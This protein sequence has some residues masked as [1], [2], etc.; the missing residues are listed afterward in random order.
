MS[1]TAMVEIIET[2]GR[3]WAISIEEEVIKVTHGRR[4]AVD[5][6]QSRAVAQNG[7]RSLQ[8]RHQHQHRRVHDCDHGA[9]ADP[10]RGPRTPRGTHRRVT[11]HK[12][13]RQEDTVP[14]KIRTLHAKGPDGNPM[15]GVMVRW[16]AEVESVPPRRLDSQEAEPWEFCELC[17]YWSVQD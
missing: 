3:Q 7:T 4:H 17:F 5:T 16:E 1:T 9:R 2:T 8:P 14:S 11:P 6:T 10:R 12:I 15:C 13:T